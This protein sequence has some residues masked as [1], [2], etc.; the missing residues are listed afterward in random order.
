M[1]EIVKVY[2]KYD[3]IPNRLIKNK[4]KELTVEEWG[5]MPWEAKYYDAVSVEKGLEGV[6]FVRYIKR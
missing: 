1:K 2:T 5:K 6:T 4:E 3:I